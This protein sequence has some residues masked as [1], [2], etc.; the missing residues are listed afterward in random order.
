MNQRLYEQLADTRQ[1]V[2][3]RALQIFVPLKNSIFVILPSVDI[4]I[5][6]NSYFR[7]RT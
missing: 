7:S 3:V 1:I 4:Q 2:A 5:S 6:K